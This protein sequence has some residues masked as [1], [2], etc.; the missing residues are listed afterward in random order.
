MPTLQYTRRRTV[1]VNKSLVGSND[2]TK[3]EK[4]YFDIDKYDIKSWQKIKNGFTQYGNLQVRNGVSPLKN[5]T[6]NEATDAMTSLLGMYMYEVGDTNYLVVAGT[7]GTDTTIMSLDRTTGAVT[8]FYTLSSQTGAC[9]FAALR[10][11]LYTVNGGVNLNIYDSITDTPATIAFSSGLK[12]AT[13]DTKRVWVVEEG[14]YGDVVY[15]SKSETGSVTSFSA[16]GTSL[17]RGGIANTNIN[18]V[19]AMEAIGNVVLLAGENLVELHEIPD[20]VESGVTTFPSE[21]PTLRKAGGVFKNFGVSTKNSVIVVGDHFY[22]MCTDGVLRVI[23]HTGSLKQE[24]DV[25]RLFESYRLNQCALGYDQKHNNLLIA[26]NEVG[27]NDRVIVFNRIDESFSEFDNIFAQQ[28]AFDKDNVYI[29]DKNLIVYDAFKENVYNDDGAEILF[30]CRTQALYL[31]G[32]TN[33]TELMQ[34]GVRAKYNGAPTMTVNIYADRSEFAQTP[35][36]STSLALANT[37]SLFNPTGQPIGLGIFG[38][39]MFNLNADK[40]RSEQ[41]NN[42]IDAHVYGTRHEIEFE[43]SVDEDFELKSFNLYFVPTNKN[44]YSSFNYTS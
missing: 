41:Y 43:V 8:D 22:L 2:F 13:A 5:V 11:Y 36:F 12:L 21:Y 37:K 29:R 14:Q 32:E 33:E 38:G 15:F 40:I 17:D 4:H 3:G 16:A 27:N 26:V 35:D 1:P 39:T 25:K 6:Q 42:L 24:Y 31:G 9:D 7:D 20:F 19:K 10:G 18:R 30:S 23:S 44:A 34:F 28:F